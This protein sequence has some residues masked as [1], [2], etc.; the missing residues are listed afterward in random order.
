[1]KKKLCLILAVCFIFCSFAF[2]VN[3]TEEIE[4]YMGIPYDKGKISI[5]STPMINPDDY[6]GEGPFDLFGIS[7]I[8][9][10]YAIGPS[11][12]FGEKEMYSVTVAPGIDIFKACEILTE[13]EWILSAEPFYIINPPYDIGE[14]SYYKNNAKFAEMTEDER[15]NFRCFIPNEIKICLDFELDLTEFDVEGDKYLFGV[16]VGKINRIE[17]EED[18]VYEIT[19]ADGIYMTN[20]QCYRVFKYNENVIWTEFETL[21]GNGDIDQ[22]GVIDSSDY[23]MVKRFA[24]NTLDMTYYTAGYAD[25][26]NDGNVDSADYVLLKRLA[27]N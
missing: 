21:Y 4:S 5:L 11:E 19:Y 7:I 14:E 20:D 22:S 26:N 25:V 13:K 3:A 8:E 12:I 2:G 18:F 15:N 23:L 17:D 16:P 6:V 1:M 9:L 10:N 27:F 24:F